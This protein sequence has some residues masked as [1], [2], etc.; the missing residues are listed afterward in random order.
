MGG[1]IP[2]YFQEVWLQ[3]VLGDEGERRRI[4]LKYD[5]VHEWLPARRGA[6][7]PSPFEGKHPPAIAERLPELR[8]RF[9]EEL[10]EVRA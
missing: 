8:Q 6:C 2:N 5:G 3:W 4:E 10:T 7:F 1:V 9:N